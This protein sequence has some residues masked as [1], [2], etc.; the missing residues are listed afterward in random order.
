MATLKQVADRAGVSRRTVDRVLNHRGTVKPETAERVREALV[1]LDYQ[2]DQAGQALAAKKKRIRLAFC[3][4]K[5]ETAVLHE[6]IR[7]GAMRKARELKKLGITVDFYTMDRDFPLTEEEA[8]CLIEGFACDGL[9]TIPYE[10]KTIKRLIGKAESMNIPMVFYNIDD[11]GYKR[12]CYVGCDYNKAGRLA[13]GLMGLC[14]QT[15][16][17]VGIFTVGG[18]EAAFRSPNYRDRVQG[19]EKEIAERFPQIQ[20]AGEYLLGWDIFDYYDTIKKVLREQP[21]MNAVYLVNPG[22]YS[23]CRAIK[24]A[25]EEKPI[26]LITNDITAEAIELLKEGVISATISQDPESQGSLPLE[27]LFEQLVYARY[28]TQEKYYTDL[29]IYIPQNFVY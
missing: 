19:F 28:P 8:H 2:P 1:E 20:I 13:A 16:L 25:M 23:V 14:A 17:E 18:S 9:V 6:E 26:R 7:Q 12:S 5:G 15:G 21:G 29:H 4:T 27:I 10:D 22:D 24:K 11:E 3:S